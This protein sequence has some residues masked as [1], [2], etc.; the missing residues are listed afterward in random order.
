MKR[1]AYVRSLVKGRDEKA[2]H[3]GFLGQWNCSI[4]YYKSGYISDVGQNSWNVQHQKWALCKYNMD[5][6]WWCVWSSFI[7][8]NKGITVVRDVNN[9]GDCACIGQGVYG[10]CT[11]HSILLCT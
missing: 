9:G 2:E 5:F 3:K 1:S 8:Y 11:S 6:G 4:W 7:D 10:N